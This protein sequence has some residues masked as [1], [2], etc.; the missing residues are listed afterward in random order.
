[1]PDQTATDELVKLFSRTG[2]P[3]I[4]HSDQGKKY[5]ATMAPAPS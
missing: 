5:C 3:E 1:M 4:L 2:I